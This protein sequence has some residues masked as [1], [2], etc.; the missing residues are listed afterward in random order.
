MEREPIGQE[1]LAILGAITG[2]FWN[3]GQS[4]LIVSCVWAPCELLRYVRKDQSQGFNITAM[5]FAGVGTLYA[6][7]QLFCYY[8]NLLLTKRETE[9]D[10]EENEVEEE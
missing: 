5:V 8:N 7:R 4:L 2:G 9:E 3:F 1:G 10:V 6:T